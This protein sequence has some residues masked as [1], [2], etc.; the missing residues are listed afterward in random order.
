M[1]L[2][3][4]LLKQTEKIDFLF[5]N[6]FEQLM[7]DE[8]YDYDKF[9]W[10]LYYVFKLDGSAVQKVSSQGKGDGGADL[11]VSFAKPDGSMY[12]IGIQAKYW[13]YRVG[14]APINQLASAKARH[15]LTHLWLITT[16][17]LTNDAKEI[18]ES[19]KIKVLRADDVKDLIEKVKQ[20]QAKEISEKGS[21]SIEFL[22]I[23]EPP[24][25]KEKKK[26]TKPRSP[27]KENV[28]EDTV[29][30]DNVKTEM[31]EQLRDLRRNIAKKYNISPIYN[32]YNNKELENLEK[33]KPKT[34]EELLKV[35]GF[36]DIKVSKFG[37]DILEFFNKL[38][39]KID[40]DQLLYNVLL[41]ERPKIARFNKLTED[42]VYT[43]RVASYLVKMKPKTKEAL[44]K[45]FDFRKENIEIFGE[46]LLRV[47]NRHIE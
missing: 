16:S 22:P 41:E 37:D 13:K 27:K 2:V 30:Q 45:I 20:Y 32:V 9:E 5:P 11:I 33:N 28:S 42:E 39:P 8:Y 44:D 4:E 40:K 29:K 38:P 19:M 47:I 31:Y 21:T 7:N 34:K 15:N 17:D 43:D 35:S 10:F 26:T 12:R 36:G 23:S 25:K 14:T 6:S 1:N 3:S 46:Y 18:A 24:V